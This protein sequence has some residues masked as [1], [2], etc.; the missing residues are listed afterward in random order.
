MIEI[1][2]MN[3]LCV[4]GLVEQGAYL[5]GGEQ[6][7]VFLPRKY[8]AKGSVLEGAYLQVFVTREVTGELVAT[9]LKP[10]VMRDEVAALSVVEVRSDLGAFL[11]WGLQKDLLLPAQEMEFPVQAGQ[12]VVVYVF[13]DPA[14]DRVFAS[15]RLRDHLS[16]LLPPYEIGQPVELLIVRPTPLGYIALVEGMHLGLLYQ[17]VERLMAGQRTQGYIGGAR[18]DGKLDLT[19][20]SSGAHRVNSL[21]EEILEALR[22]AGGRLELDDASPPEAIREKFGASKK[23]FKQAVGSLYKQRLIEL[24]RPGLA[25][26]REPGRLKKRGERIPG[27]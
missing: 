9:T 26:I 3:R 18:E 25:L 16:P 7:E 22:A 11:A 8:F 14:S 27:S 19:L 20:D 13:L 4:V 17:G 12:V 24:M 1:G 21:T 6:G 2:K 15:T 5:E 23:A 10:L